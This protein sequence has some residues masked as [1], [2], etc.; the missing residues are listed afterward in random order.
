M[1]MNNDIIQLIKI[2][3]GDRVDM[4]LLR[5]MSMSM[6]PHFSFSQVKRQ[7]RY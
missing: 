4:Q 3:R 5:K 2:I 6:R 1:L 7:G